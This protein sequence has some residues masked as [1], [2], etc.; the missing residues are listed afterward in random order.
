MP[1]YDFACQNCGTAYEKRL[2]MSAYS[3]REGW[4]CPECGSSE[5]ERRFTAVNVIGGSG[6]GRTS[7]TAC[8][9]RG[10]FT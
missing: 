3:A 5:V 2:S 10:G 9:P 1:S 7:G 6:P 4:E 8:A